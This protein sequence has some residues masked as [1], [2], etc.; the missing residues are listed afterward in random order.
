[1]VS[2]FFLLLVVALSL[3]I[4]RVGSVAFLMT[5]LSEEVSQFQSL[6]AFSG[7]GFTTDEAETIV[8]HPARRR[9]AALL[10]RLGS[11]GLVTSIAPLLLSFVGA[12]SATPERLLVLG[13]GGLAL[14]VLGRSRL[15]PHPHAV[16]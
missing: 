9:I 4:I 11:V 15:C 8:Q 12:G 5:G 14:F 3:L 2:V 10:I 1:M 16:D 7:T 13:A 6:S